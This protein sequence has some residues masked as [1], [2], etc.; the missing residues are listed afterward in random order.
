[1]NKE[2]IK[3]FENG[4]SIDR[5]PNGKYSVFTVKTKRFTIDSLE[6]L[7][8]DTFEKIIADNKIKEDLKNVK[9]QKE[10]SAFYHLL[11]E[12]PSPTPKL[13][14]PNDFTYQYFKSIADQTPKDDL[15]QATKYCMEL[16][17]GTKYNFYVLMVN[18]LHKASSD[19]AGVLFVRVETGKHYMFSIGDLK[20]L[21]KSFTIIS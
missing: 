7:T 10:N 4:I 13:V 16:N 1:M 5:L 9:E 19:S 14:S 15:S 8:P 17:D 20:K 6:E 3:Y 18:I 11:G 12:D 21:V 2:L